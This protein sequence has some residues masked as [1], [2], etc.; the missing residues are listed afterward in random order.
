MSGN[1]KMIS[2]LLED[3]LYCSCRFFSLAYFLYLKIHPNIRYGSGLVIKGK[4]I[5]EILNRGN[6][7]LGNDVTL[8]STPRNYFAHLASPVRLFV[9]GQKAFI[10]I[11][12]NTRINGATIHARSRIIIGNNCLIAANT[13]IVDSHGHKNCFSA[14]DNRINTTDDPKDIVIED[15]VWIGL[16]CIILKGAR[17][18]YGS[19]IGAGSVV[20][21]DIPPYS[22]ARG[23]PAQ[24]IKSSCAGKKM[25]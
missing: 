12:D 11:G 25:L 9:E 18:G 10:R 14:P 16:S 21:S 13:S 4:P 2:K 7:E 1:H 19:I 17:I 20:V 15:S 23:N 5:I 22:I 24:V 6:I 8:Y 3:P